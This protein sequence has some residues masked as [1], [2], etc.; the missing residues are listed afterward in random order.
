MDVEDVR[1]AAR[2][3]DLLHVVEVLDDGDGPFEA[4]VVEDGKAAVAGLGGEAGRGFGRRRLAGE[5]DVDA[6]G[7]QL[8][9]EVEGGL[10]GAGPLPVAEEVEDAHEGPI[11]TL[12][13]LLGSP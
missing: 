1:V 9:A 6:E 11:I 8:E 12:D 13:P 2:V 7:P 3:G 5:G 4:E 10:G